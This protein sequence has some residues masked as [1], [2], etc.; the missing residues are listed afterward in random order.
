MA[1]GVVEARQED[2]APKVDDRRPRTRGSDYVG[3]GA[4]GQDTVT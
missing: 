4:N 2:T 1:V 3:L